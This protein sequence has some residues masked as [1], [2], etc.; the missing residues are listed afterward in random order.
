MR[1]KS[2]LY[3]II[4]LLFCLAG[5]RAQTLASQLDKNSVAIGELA[6]LTI[7]IFDLNG[8]KVH[9]APKNELLPFH[10]EENKD[11]EQ[12]T[13]QEYTRTITFQIFQEGNFKIPPL[14]F[15]IG[16]KVYQ[17]VPYEVEVVSTL[18]PGADM[19]DIVGNR[20][21]KLSLGDY[22][23]LYK[24]YVLG[25]LLL[26]AV[27]FAVYFLVKYGKKRKEPEVVNLNATLKALKSLKAK[28]YPLKGDYRSFYVELIDLLRNFLSVQLKIPAKVL[29]TDD[30]IEHLKKMNQIQP[31]DEAALEEL[32]IRGD[33]VKFAKTF[34]DREMMTKDYEV[35]YAFVQKL[36][37][38]INEEK[39]RSGV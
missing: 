17:T 1:L 27:I 13:D 30:L 31:A 24:F 20:E 5:A 23:H 39:L 21:V 6:T 34:P 12:V 3:C 25:A 29:L 18:A 10:F 14:D 28:N 36:S 4:C 26:L 11:V 9:T 7:K 22:W 2:S 16:N 37:K 38:D 19:A 8:Q 32:L 35:V 15:E 33:L